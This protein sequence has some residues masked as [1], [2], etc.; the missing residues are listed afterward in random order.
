MIVTYTELG[1]HSFSRLWIIVQKDIQTQTEPVLRRRSVAWITLPVLPVFNVTPGWSRTSKCPPLKVQCWKINVRSKWECFEICGW[2]NLKPKRW[3]KQARLINALIAS[4]FLMYVQQTRTFTAGN[5][6][7]H[8]THR[9]NY[10]PIY[11]DITCPFIRRRV[12]SRNSRI[13]ITVEQ[14]TLQVQ[15]RISD[16]GRTA[17]AQPHF[18]KRRSLYIDQSYSSYESP[19]SLS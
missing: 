4:K 5:H 11:R 8:I 9:Y 17:T 18:I 7:L 13:I 10:A 6:G 16:E 1:D 15:C 12:N 14:S 19:I 3:R 2:L